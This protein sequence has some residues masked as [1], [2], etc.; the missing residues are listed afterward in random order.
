MAKKKIVFHKKFI[1]IP[2]GAAAIAIIIVA[3]LFIPDFPV[4]V[5][6]IEPIV[7]QGDPDAFVG[8][9]VDQDEANAVIV[10]ISNPICDV[11]STVNPNDPDH[12]CD[13]PDMTVEEIA[14][15]AEEDGDEIIEEFEETIPPSSD[16]NMTETSEDPPAEQVCD[17]LDLGCGSS[18]PINLLLNV[19]KIDA[20]N[21][22]FNSTVVTAVP[23]LSF[24]VEQGTNIDFTNGFIEFSFDVETFADTVVDGTGSIEILISNQTIQQANIQISGMTDSEGIANV[25]FVGPTGATSNTLIFSFADNMD[26]FPT[27]GLTPIE[28]KL[29]DLQIHR[30]AQACIAIFPVPP[31]CEPADHAISNTVIFTMEIATDVNEIIIED[32]T[33]EL[34]RVYPTDDRFIIRSSTI[35]VRGGICYSLD[36]NK[37]LAA[38]PGNFGRLWTEPPVKLQD[39]CGRAVTGV[40]AGTAPAPPI[41]GINLFRN[42]EFVKSVAGATNGVVFDELLTRN[43]NYTITIAD[44]S[45]TFDFTTPKS[46]RNYDYKCWYNHRLNYGVTIQQDS[47]GNRNYIGSLCPG[48]TYCSSAVSVQKPPFV[49]TTKQ[50]NF[51]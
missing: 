5:F 11:T 4:N 45:V 40:T 38:V 8:A 27:Q 46:Q 51:E 20:D 15:T 37:W 14:E 47:S 19:V 21:N 35:I 32:E 13:V 6:G 1:W 12:I 22:R 25:L 28:F 2:A 23:A 26:K 42:G 7:P 31:Q 30:E 16:L 39:I 34:V 29:V 3:P 36:V 49:I 50:C 10:E 17:E 43:T 24:F 41:S 44:P 18:S 9:F 48:A 33:G